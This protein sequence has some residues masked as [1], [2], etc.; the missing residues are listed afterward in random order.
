MNKRTFWIYACVGV[1]M[2]TCFFIF[3]V[4]LWSNLSIEWRS[5]NSAGIECID[6]L[7]LFLDRSNTGFIHVKSSMHPITSLHKWNLFTIFV[8]VHQNIVV[9]DR[10]FIE[11]SSKLP[12]STTDRRLLA[13]LCLF[14]TPRVIWGLFL[15]LSGTFPKTLFFSL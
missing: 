12:N 9:M 3:M 1:F 7:L 8:Q 6:G 2:V 13:F 14:Q 15:F 5:Q 10:I 11:K 4:K